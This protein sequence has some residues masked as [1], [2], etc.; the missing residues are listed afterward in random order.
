MIPTIPP[1]I[2]VNSPITAWSL[3]RMVF[4]MKTLNVSRSPVKMPPKVSPLTA[5]APNQ[6]ATN[7]DGTIDL[8]KKASAMAIIGGKIETHGLIA[9][10]SNS[11]IF[12][13]LLPSEKDA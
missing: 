5:H 10:F 11:N 6:I 7:K 4:R 8:V 2:S 1:S 3:S 12:R 13:S 9:Y